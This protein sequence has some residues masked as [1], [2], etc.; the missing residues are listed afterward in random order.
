MSEGMS[1]NYQPS[2]YGSMKRLNPE[3]II[4]ATDLIRGTNNFK[5]LDADTMEKIRDYIEKT[6]VK[7][8][9]KLAPLKNLGLSLATI[10]VGVLLTR[11]SANRLFYAMK[12]KQF[13]QKAFAKIGDKLFKGIEVATK[14]AKFNET[15][16][17]V[18]KYFFKGVE[19]VAKKIG[20]IAE[21]GIA[22]DAPEFVTK[23]GENL[24]KKAFQTAGTGVGLVTTGAALSV[25]KDGDGKSDII[26]SGDVTSTQKKNQ[27]AVID[28][29]TAILEAV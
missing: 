12:D 27:A 17:T 25:D 14:N 29:M 7:D 10:G 21:K 16:G 28:L 20:K 24:T 3:A 8:G 9:S 4:R 22:K 1:V 26:N 5:N 2:C 13:V 23:V 19:Y 11:G 15:A 6:E 18:R